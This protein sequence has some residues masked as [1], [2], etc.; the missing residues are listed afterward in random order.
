MEFKLDEK[1]L[2]QLK[3]WQEKIKSTYGKYGAYSYI[4]TP[5]GIGNSV[6]VKSHLTE[7]YIDLS[8]EEDW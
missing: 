8:N 7:T 3:V 1:Q 4:F 2:G 5:T 6:Q